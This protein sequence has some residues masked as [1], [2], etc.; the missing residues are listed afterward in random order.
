MATEQGSS[1]PESVAKLIQAK[2]TTL[3]D[4]LGSEDLPRAIQHA[5]PDFVDFMSK[6]EILRELIDW[7]LTTKKNKHPSFRQYSIN[8]MDLL[9]TDFGGFL[10]KLAENGYM[11]NALREFTK[12]EYGSDPWAAGHFQRIVDSFG[13]LTFGKFISEFTELS[14]YLFVNIQ[15]LALRELFILLCTDFPKS[16]HFNLE[17][18]KR[19]CRHLKDVKNQY[20][21]VSSFRII[22]RSVSSLYA[23]FHDPEI[24]RNLLDLGV[25]TDKALVAQECFA[26]LIKLKQ[27]FPDID[28]IIKEYDGKYHFDPNNTNCATA[29]ALAL[30]PSGLPLFIDQFFDFPAKTILDYSLVKSIMMITDDELKVLLKEHNIV[31]K[32]IEN[33][34][35]SKTNG[36]LTYLADILSKK[37]PLCPELNTP[38]WNEFVKTKLAK[39]LSLRDG[40]YGGELPHSVF[41]SYDDHALYIDHEFEINNDE[42]FD[43]EE[44]FSDGDSEAEKSYDADY[45]NDEYDAEPVEVGHSKS[46]ATDHEGGEPP[47]VAAFARKSGAESD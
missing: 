15:N 44:T 34:D 29:A 6:P 10:T 47:I 26:F 18:A 39:R 20:Y 14:H 13:K 40:S 27:G 36:H 30:F 41:S 17:I 1:F 11:L 25:T 3:E 5:T 16:Y 28:P 35:K 9:T 2:E 19:V 46:S 32:I 33:F 8:C 4:I 22:V 38:E 7:A 42:N 43:E 24:V 45:D 21:L 12:S 23:A 37:G 31:N